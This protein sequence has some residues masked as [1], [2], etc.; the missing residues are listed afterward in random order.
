MHSHI[1]TFFHLQDVD[2]KLH[3]YSPQ[4]L[5]SFTWALA[6][7]ST[8]PPQPWLAKALALFSHR[9]SGAGPLGLLQMAGALASLR[10]LGR[11]QLPA[12]FLMRLCLAAD[13]VKS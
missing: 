9:I 12:G 5:A 11:T 2:A 13:V 6:A 7:W 10:G 3:T 1:A 8:P 4:A